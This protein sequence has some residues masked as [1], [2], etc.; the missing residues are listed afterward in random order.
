MKSHVAD[1]GLSVTPVVATSDSFVLRAEEDTAAVAMLSKEV[2]IVRAVTLPAD[3]MAGM[4][5]T[6]S[7][8]A[9]VLDQPM[10][11]L[12]AT[13]KV[14]VTSRANT[15]ETTEPADPPTSTDTWAK[16]DSPQQVHTPVELRVQLDTPQASRGVFSY[17]RTYGP[18]AQP[19]GHSF[20]IW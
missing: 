5:V 10:A 7:R 15:L 2:A 13:A 19:S 12:A 20:S 3:T 8:T 14:R 11:R 6:T 4:A 17:I 1:I 16:T 18:T 9:T